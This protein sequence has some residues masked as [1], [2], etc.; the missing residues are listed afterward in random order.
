MIQRRRYIEQIR[1][2][3][4]S[5]LVKL[6][7][8][9][10]H[11]GKR[12]LLRQIEE[13]FHQQNKPTLRLDFDEPSTANAIDSIS[14]LEAVVDQALCAADGQKL[15]VF[16]TEVQNLSDWH[17]ACRSLRLKNL[18]LFVTSSTSVVLTREFTREL[19]GRYVS[20]RLHPFV[21]KELCAGNRTYP[22][23]GYLMLGGFPQVLDSE[24]KT[25]TPAKL[26]A[27]ESSIMG[28]IVRRYRIR[29]DEIFRQLA[30]IVLAS[31]ARILSANA[32]CHALK[33][34]GHDVTITTV[35]KFLDYLKETYLI[36]AVP[37]FDTKAKRA[38][39]YYEKFYAI[40][41]GLSTIRQINNRPNLTRNLENIVYNELLY[42]GYAL[43][44][45]R[46]DSHTIDFLAVKA[47]KEYLVQVAYSIAEPCTYEREFAPFHRLDNSRLKIIITNDEADFSTSTVRHICLKNFLLSDD[48]E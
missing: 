14:T 29:K 23:T 35:C 1:P 6:V 20:F 41:A 46:H 8:G 16:L 25:A 11:C 2:F 31:N 47:G 18:S 26:K 22:V 44:V 28:D 15:Y 27:I 43:Q 3:F 4:E 32:V 36:D 30:N 34:E 45:F 39:S 33:E 21:Y 13:N 38:L 37:I 48:L 12:T 5:D 24:K 7:T 9:V 42:R 40:D 19:S 10:R 17:V